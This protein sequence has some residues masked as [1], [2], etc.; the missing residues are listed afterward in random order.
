MTASSFEPAPPIEVRVLSGPNLY[1]TR[2][3]TK[4]VLDATHILDL[5]PVLAAELGNLLLPVGGRAGASG[6]DTRL[7]FAAQLAAAL[8]RR[9]A[10][11]FGKE[12]PVVH[13]V[14]P[15]DGQIT[16]AFPTRWRRRSES[17][18]YTINA[19]VQQLGTIAPA[20]DVE[21]ALDAVV[22]SAIDT[23][24]MADLGDEVI[25][26]VPQVPTIAITG[27]NGKTT[28][29]RLVAHIGSVAGRTPGWS[30]TDGI[31]IDGEIVEVG[32]WSGPGGAARVLAEPKVD[33]AVLETA[34]GGVL[35][36][37]M[38]T[39][40]N[41]VGVVT[42]IS[43]DH[44]GLNGIYTVEQL[45]EVKST[46]VRATKPAG[47]AVLNGDD[48][49]VAPMRWVTRAHPWIFTLDP[50]NP[51]IADVL[52][53]G[54]R[55]TTVIDGWI[56]VLRRGLDPLALVPIDQVPITLVGLS[57]V[58]LYNA[59]AAASAALAIG[60]EPAAVRRGL[61]TFVPDIAGNP[62]RLNIFNVAGMLVVL[63]LA[64]NEASLD[65]LLAVADGLRRSGQIWTIL[66]APGDRPDDAVHAMGR[67][68]AE[69]SDHL[70]VAEKEKYRRDRPAG[71]LTTLFRGGA[72]DAGIL[73]LPGFETELDAVKHV[74]GVAKPQ[75]VVAVMVHAEHAEISQWLRDQGGY[76]MDHAA[77]V[78]WLR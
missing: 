32:D 57:R 36:R 12:L 37:G 58:N 41:D 45:A 62:G 51:L 17:M 71:E 50:D 59:L 5:D 24:E 54:G 73:D 43:P 77:L 23:V 19:A 18:A 29:T 44:L 53:I 69:M 46:I 78:D 13:Q 10:R 26:L 2:P 60:I 40:T 16:I 15:E 67:R 27:T 76:E 56:V 65:A 28:T 75:D 25:A 8:A 20:E 48:E 74:I 21:A 64:H 47:W 66:G 14:G 9:I 6:G 49:L 63:D 3:A 1:L 42:N 39:A 34:R 30:N 72:A 11:N 33:L 22:A 35:L 52:V 7:E 31:V 55:V 70:A 61:N 4:L 68:A 38:G